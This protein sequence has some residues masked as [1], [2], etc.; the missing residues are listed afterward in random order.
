MRMYRIYAL[1]DP[2][3]RLVRYV[4]RT[5]HA[6]ETRYVA[7]ASGSTRGTALWVRTLALPPVAVLLEIGE[8]KRIS[9]K[10]QAGTISAGAFAETKWIK[11]FRRTIINDLQREV[12]PTT[13]DWLVNPDE[14]RKCGPIA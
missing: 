2:T 7:H 14:R 6:L 5:H 8:E 13:W 3:S 12:S 1:V 4:G 11:R 10:G 9:R